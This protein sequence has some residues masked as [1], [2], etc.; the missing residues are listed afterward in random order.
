MI[1]KPKVL[2]IISFMIIQHTG[3]MKMTRCVCVSLKQNRVDAAYAGG[4]IRVSS[5]SRLPERKANAARNR[6]LRRACTCVSIGFFFLILDSNVFPLYMQWRGYC[7]TWMN[8]KIQG[9]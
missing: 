7:G 2:G 9:S 1:W 3:K 4:R 5:I 8:G 6:D